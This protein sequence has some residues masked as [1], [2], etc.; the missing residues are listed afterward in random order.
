MPKQG[1]FLMLALLAA[2]SGAMSFPQHGL[3]QSAAPNAARSAPQPGGLQRMTLLVTDVDKAIDFYQRAGL[4]KSSDTQATDTD[5]G[6]VYGAA[7]L[8]L[9]ADSKHSRL[10]VMQNGDG[11]GQ[12]GLLAYDRPPLPSARGNLVG[13][14]VGDVVINIEVP[15]IQ[16]AYSRLGQIGTRFQRTVVRFTQTGADGGAQTGQH[17]LAFDP[18]GHMVEVSQMD[19]R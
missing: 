5:V 1:M 3:A 8:P 13:I 9:T 14:G 15:D 18:D 16:A 12:L 4:V 19:K 6:G 17:F 2:T 11:R 10:A 7:D